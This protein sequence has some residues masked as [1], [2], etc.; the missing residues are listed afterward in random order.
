MLGGK[1]S[2]GT[3]LASWDGAML[4]VVNG[5]SAGSLPL[6]LPQLCLWLLQGM[7]NC[8]CLSHGTS[9]HY[10]ALQCG[11]QAQR[12]QQT[13]QAMLRARLWPG[14]DLNPIVTTAIP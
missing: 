14:T 9:Q 4:S 11:I 5:S 10:W 2:V 12:C 7:H 3:S 13:G 8:T 6:R 1:Q